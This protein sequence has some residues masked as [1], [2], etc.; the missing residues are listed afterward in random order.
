MIE[1][2]SARGRA[3]SYIARHP[4]CGLEDIAGG[5]CLTKRTVWGLIG[6]LRPLI[7][8]IKTGRKHSYEVKDRRLCR[9][10]VDHVYVMEVLEQLEV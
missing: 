8:V 1:L 10:L 7:R 9:V 4:G 2:L 3:L 6:G 5:L